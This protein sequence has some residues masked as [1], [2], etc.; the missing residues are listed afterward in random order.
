MNKELTKEEIVK[1]QIDEALELIESGNI[2]G[3]LEILKDIKQRLE[4]K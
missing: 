2:A 4:I 1:I 3:A